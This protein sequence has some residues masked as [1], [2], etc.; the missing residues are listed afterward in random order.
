MKLKT[1]AIRILCILIAVSLLWLITLL[2]VPKYIRNTEGRLISEY[3]RETDAGREH[4]VI[5]LGDCEIYESFIPPLLF[6]EYGITSFVRG[7]AGQTL[8][9]SRYLLEEV[10]TYETPEA[11]VLGVYGARY[12]KA[13]REEYNRMTLDGMRTSR[14]KHLAVVGSLLEGE[15][16][17]SYYFPILRFH[18]R[19]QSLS[20]EDVFLRR[21]AQVSHN[22]YLLQTGVMPQERDPI[23]DEMT[24]DLSDIALGQ[25]RDIAELCGQRGI[26]LILVKPP[27]CS[28][29]YWWYDEWDEKIKDI[30][31]ELGIDYYNLLDH[32]EIGIDMQKHSYDGGMHLNVY[33]A[34]RVTLYFGKLLSEKY[35]LSNMQDDVEV[36]EVWEDKIRDFYSDME[37]QT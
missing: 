24:D 1:F 33:G 22:G 18:S 7:S 11:V 28:E 29:K 10:L 4:S 34:K 26:K 5:F 9:Q 23:P 8:L 21:D 14:I 35:L 15:S 13:S 32:S 16:I 37:E 6:E 3:Y 36:C 2:L 17:L 30:S 25:I 20:R 31:Q 19:W 27:V 12:S